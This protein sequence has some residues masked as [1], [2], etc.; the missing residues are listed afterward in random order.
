MKGTD[1]ARDNEANPWRRRRGLRVRAHVRRSRAVRAPDPPRRRACRVGS[2]PIVARPAPAVPPTPVAGTGDCATVMDAV[3]VIQH[4]YASGSLLTE[5]A[6]RRLTTDLD[7][8]DRECDPDTARE[9]RSR[10]LTPWLT[11]LPP[12]PG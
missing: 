3:R 7:R 9:F 4:R 11:Y 5:T 8:L 6:N 10:E 1:D 2:E 12:R